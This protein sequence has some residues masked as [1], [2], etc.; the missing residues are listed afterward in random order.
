MR[1]HSLR[2]NRS[3]QSAL[4][5]PGSGRGRY[6]NVGLQHSLLAV[7][8]PSC[9]AA[10]GVTVQVLL[11]R[12]RKSWGLWR[13]CGGRCT[14]QVAPRCAGGGRRECHTASRQVT[15]LSMPTRPP[16]GLPGANT[17]PETGRKGLKAVLPTSKRQNYK[18]KA[19]ATRVLSLVGVC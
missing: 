6:G 5:R 11:R 10:R 7:P 18:G 3:R 1:C 13:S 16:P 2:L 8:A 19:K 15:V 14:R 4:R 12:G 17:R 9:R